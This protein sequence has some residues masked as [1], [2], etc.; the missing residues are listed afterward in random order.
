MEGFLRT[1][2]RDSKLVTLN[3]CRMYLQVIFL[4]DICNGQG[5]TI[6]NQFWS[7]TAISNSHNFRW[8]CTH[9]PNPSKWGLWQRALTRSFNLNNT[10]KLPIPLGK[11]DSIT[12]QTNGWYTDE[13][14]LQLFHQTEQEWT[15]FTPLPSCRRTRSFLDKATPTTLHAMPKLLYRSTNYHHRLWANEIRTN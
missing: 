7:G 12:T 4:S 5:T 10:W 2:Y 1:G 15:T 11:W 9:K 13:A 8:P 3:R 14:G 6:E